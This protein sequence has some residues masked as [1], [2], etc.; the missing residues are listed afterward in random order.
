MLSR[1]P[2]KRP[3]FFLTKYAMWHHFWKV[4]KADSRNANKCYNWH[5]SSFKWRFLHLEKRYPRNFCWFV[6]GFSRPL[7]NGA[8]SYTLQEKKSDILK[9]WNFDFFV[10][11][12]R[13][14]QP[15]FINCKF[16]KN[17]YCLLR[18]VCESKNISWPK[19]N[20]MEGPFK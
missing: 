2:R 7:R 9:I 17:L 6:N 15:R 10:I 4:L 12:I 18:S 3:I 16:F 13:Y 11:L 1:G 20:D 14:L 19:N 5:I 8:T